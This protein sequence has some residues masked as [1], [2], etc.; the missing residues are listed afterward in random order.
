MT[1]DN[2]LENEYAAHLLSGKSLPISYDT[3][4]TQYQTVAS[5]GYAVNISRAFTRLIFVFVTFYGLGLGVRANNDLKNDGAEIRKQF[6]DF[7]NPQGWSATPVSTSE[8][9]FSMQLGSKMY[10][11]YPIRSLEEAFTQVQKC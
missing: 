11:E 3:Y 4:V 8:I 5:T 6:L 1:S 2:G 9:V 10:P 7:Y